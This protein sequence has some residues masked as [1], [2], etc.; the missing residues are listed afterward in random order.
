MEIL[1]RE[2]TSTGIYRITS[3]EGGAFFIRPE[4]LVSLPKEDFLINDNFNEEQ[5]QEILDAGLITA[6]EC[7]AVEYLARSEQCRS[8][9]L[10]KLSDKG[11]EKEYINRALTYLES[12]NYLSDERFCGS[13][14]NT[15]KINHSEGRTKLLSELLGK[16]IKKEIA[17]SALDE[18]FAENN[19]N[20][21]AERCYAK[22]IK[23]G[24]SGEKLI[25][26][27]IQQGFSYKIACTLI[28][29]NGFIPQD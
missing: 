7:K 20:Q 13:W 14:L 25:A 8:G 6:C 29:N 5:T 24:K 1:S 23:K 11:Y 19:E 17:N 4:Y 12:V 27:L 10:K 2:V 3:S 28:K 22:L 16:G 21:I 26:A 18:F 9:L 15:R